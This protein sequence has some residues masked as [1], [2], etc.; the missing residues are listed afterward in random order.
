MKTPST[1]LYFCA[2]TQFFSKY[3]LSTKCVSDAWGTW[4]TQNVLSYPWEGDVAYSGPSG[5]PPVGLS[6]ALPCWPAP[7]PWAERQWLSNAPRSE[8]RK[9]LSWLRR[10][11][12]VNVRWQSHVTSPWCP[13]H[14]SPVLFFL[15]WA[16]LKQKL[17]NPFRRKFWDW[18][19]SPACAGDHSNSIVLSRDSK[20]NWSLSRLSWREKGTLWNVNVRVIF[21]FHL[22]PW[23]NR[24][25]LLLKNAFQFTF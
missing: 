22:V 6:P 10:S 5:V 19:A 12:H 20:V 16:L 14:Q 18:P 4:T 2:F 25:L 1:Y 3:F 8:T 21:G 17:I 15:F 13:C 11:K 24:E 7:V 23:R 9:Q